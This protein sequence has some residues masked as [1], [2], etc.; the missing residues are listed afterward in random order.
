[1]VFPDFLRDIIKILLIVEIIENFLR[2]RHFT[3]GFLNRLQ[4]FGLEIY[5]PFL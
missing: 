2:W 3:G 1:M 4:E 5:L